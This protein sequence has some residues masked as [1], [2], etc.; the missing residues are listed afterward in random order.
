MTNNDSASSD[1]CPRRRLSKYAGSAVAMMI[2]GAWFLPA[3]AEE[4]AADHRIGHQSQHWLD[5]QTSGALATD[6]QREMAGPVAER[7]YQRYLD[8][9]T[10]PIPEQFPRE[11]FSGDSGS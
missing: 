6:T 9:F 5:I 8:S 7:V 10:H 11:S 2:A 3:L 1:R 4:P